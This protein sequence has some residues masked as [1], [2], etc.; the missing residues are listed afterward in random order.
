MLVLMS[1]LCA[2]EQFRAMAPTRRSS[3]SLPF[4]SASDLLPHLY[5]FFLLSVQVGVPGERLMAV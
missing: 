5:F 3:R 4:S 1:L 2:L